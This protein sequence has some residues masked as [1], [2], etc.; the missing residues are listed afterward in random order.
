MAACLP[1]GIAGTAV[2]AL[3]THVLPACDRVPFLPQAGSADLAVKYALHWARTLAA[4]NAVGDIVE[5][6]PA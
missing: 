4:Y 3:L 1:A 6:A 2:A 5:G